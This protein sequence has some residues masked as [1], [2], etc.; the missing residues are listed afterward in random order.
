MKN[1]EKIELIAKVAKVEEKENSLFVTIAVNRSEK[2]DDNYVQKTNWY[3]CIIAKSLKC[4]VGD[5]VFVR[6]NLKID[7]YIKNNG[8]PGVSLKVFVSEWNVLF[9][10]NIQIEEDN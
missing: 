4:K 1:L 6:G 8:E 10:K 9:E 2:I 3:T 5:T 7:L